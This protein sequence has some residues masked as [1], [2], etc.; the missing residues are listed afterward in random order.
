MKKHHASSLCVV[1]LLLAGVVLF[2][3]VTYY[4]SHPHRSGP[5]LAI[6]ILAIAVG[7]VAAAG[8]GKSQP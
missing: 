8:L 7:L 1:A 2:Q 3:E 6:A 4:V 5:S